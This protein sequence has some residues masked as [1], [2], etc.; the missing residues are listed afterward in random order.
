MGLWNLVELGFQQHAEKVAIIHDERRVTF[1]DLEKRINKM[2]N[3][4]YGL[5]LKKGDSVSIL[6]ENSL[7]AVEVQYALFKGGFVWVP[8]SFRNQPRENAYYLNNAGVKALVMQSQFAQGMEGVRTDIQT[9]EHYIVDGKDDFGMHRYEHLMSRASDDDQ[10]IDVNNNEPLGLLHTSGTTGKA[11]GVVHTHRNWAMLAFSAIW[12]LG[13]QSTDVVLH[14]GSINHGSGSFICPHLMMGV[15]QVLAN[16]MDVEFVFRTIQK[17]RVTTV[18]LAPTMI[19]L[20]LDHPDI[21]N[22]DLCSLRVMPYSSAPMAVHKLKEALRVFGNKFQQAYGL[23][24]CPLITLLSPK[25]HLNATLGNEKALRHLASAGQRALMTDVRIVAGDG[26]DLPRGAV[27]EIAVRSPLV[28]K[29]YWKD[30]A[31]TSKSLRNGWL[32][33]GDVGYLDDD[34]YLFIK[35]RAKDMLIT[36]GFNVYPR[37]VEDA[38]LKHPAVL[39]TAVIGVPDD[40]WGESV[41]AFVVL[42]PGMKASEEDIIS[43]CKENLSSY[44]KPRSVDFVMALPRNHA[45]KV[46]KTEL[47]KPYWEGR[48]RQ[49]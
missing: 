38:I 49:V 32:F 11:K 7:M 28:M 45:G 21:R 10:P 26:G 40:L 47:R 20:M 35:D 46:L 4:L 36:G 43:V 41:K 17:E 33:T 25:D 3:A 22:Y 23:T 15:P 5:G 16:H 1:Q 9:V 14:I 34:G 37:E 30:P 18:W 6:A 31:A 39:E 42:K 29:E 48:E 13:I 19:Y 44:K 27:G 12:S 24:E 2:V 8:L